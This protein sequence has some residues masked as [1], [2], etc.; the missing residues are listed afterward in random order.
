MILGWTGDYRGRSWTR[1]EMRRRDEGRR[2]RGESGRKSTTAARRR[3]RRRRRLWRRWSRDRARRNRS[4]RRRPV[5]DGEVPS[6]RDASRRVARP[7]RRRTSVETRG[8]PRRVPSRETFSAVSTITS[9]ARARGS[10]SA[11]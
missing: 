8:E 11:S 4:E 2:R 9:T 3:G 5:A 1:R 7:R 10:V 6:A